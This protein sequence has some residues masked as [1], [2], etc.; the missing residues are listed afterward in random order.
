M[1]EGNLSPEKYF[2]TAEGN[3][4]GG[5]LNATTVGRSVGLV[6]LGGCLTLQ[7]VEL[8]RRKKKKKKKLLRSSPPK[9]EHTQH[10]TRSKAATQLKGRNGSLEKITAITQNFRTVLHRQ[11]LQAWNFEAALTFTSSFSLTAKI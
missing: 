8:T 5:G 4:G 2:T 10:N 1:S 7:I 6:A 9:T 3:G 11:V